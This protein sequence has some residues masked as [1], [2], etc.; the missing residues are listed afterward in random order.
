M[1]S[2]MEGGQNARVRGERGDFPRRGRWPKLHASLRV[3]VQGGM[4]PTSVQP[5][6]DDMPGE[7]G[8]KQAMRK[9]GGKRSGD[10]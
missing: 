5:P 1:A 3:L 7:G 8:K 9:E 4:A 6:P 10:A 2:A